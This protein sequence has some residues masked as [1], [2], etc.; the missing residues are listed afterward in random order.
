MLLFRSM[1][2]RIHFNYYS[3][4]EELLYFNIYTIYV[5]NKICTQIQTY[6]II[7]HVTKLIQLFIQS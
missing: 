2:Q 1:E 4:H 6:T 7:K 3:K 5:Y